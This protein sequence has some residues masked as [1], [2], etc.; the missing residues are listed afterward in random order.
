MLQS[1]DTSGLLRLAWFWHQLIALSSSLEDHN[2]EVRLTM[3]LTF[4]AKAKVVNAPVYTPS[5][6]R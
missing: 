6:F 4:P 2:L 1:Y 3:D 5:S